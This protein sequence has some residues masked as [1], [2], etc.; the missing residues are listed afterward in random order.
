MTRET[1]LLDFDKTGSWARAKE[2]GAV[3]KPRSRANFVVRLTDSDDG[4]D[5][6]LIYDPETDR[7]RGYCTCRGFQYHDQVCAH[8]WALKIAETR[9]A[10][11]IPTGKELLEKPD[12]CPQ[13]GRGYDQYREAK[14]GM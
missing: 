5:T 1:R 3:I 7:Y 13:C 9:N 6:T 4:H 12:H 2:N 8:L 10:L 11:N 14:R